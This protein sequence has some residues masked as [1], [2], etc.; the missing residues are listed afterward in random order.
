MYFGTELILIVILLF[1][2]GIGVS[3]YYFYSDQQNNLNMLKMQLSLNN[4]PQSNNIYPPTN[5]HIPN[6]ISTST[7]TPQFYNT[8]VS[9]N[10]NFN[11]TEKYNFDQNEHIDQSKYFKPE[12][13][14]DE[15]IIKSPNMHMPMPPV[16]PI[17]IYDYRVLEDPMKDPK[18]RLPRY[19]MGPTVASP[20][21]N[22][23]TRGLRDSFSQQGY[24]IDNRAS[25]SD[26]NKI[27][28]LFGRQKWPNSSRYEY[29]V[30]FQSG[31]KDRKYDLD[32]YTK[33]LYDKDEVLVDILND[34]RYEV[35][36][37]KQEGLEYN[38]FWF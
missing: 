9:H 16:D 18:R 3:N 29:Y 15:T 12:L 1:V 33:E 35:K 27:L 31:D 10:Q 23:P 20:L 8:S 32:R 22:F 30:T 13:Q 21:F 38:P 28:Q 34:R 14:I 5:T 17:K 7:N 4:I 37:F 26:S 2:I 24:L 25:T 11:E 36:L 6:N 19:L